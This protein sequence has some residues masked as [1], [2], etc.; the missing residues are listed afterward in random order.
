MSGCGGTVEEDVDDHSSGRERRVLGDLMFVE[1]ST[2]QFQATRVEAEFSTA[3]TAS[4]EDA[5]GVPDGFPATGLGRGG[6]EPSRRTGICDV[7]RLTDRW[8]AS[9]P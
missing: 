6:A 5:G 9:T 7:G 2:L 3:Y 1:A 4:H 8:V